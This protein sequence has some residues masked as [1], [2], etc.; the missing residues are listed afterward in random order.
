MKQVGPGGAIRSSNARAAAKREAI[1]GQSAQPPVRVGLVRARVVS[2]DS[3][4]G[5]TVA[6]LNEDGTASA[7]EVTVVFPFP[8]A[9]FA[10]GA[11]VVLQVDRPNAHPWIVGTGAGGAAVDETLATTMLG[12]LSEV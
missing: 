11:D 5:Y 10:A 9:T 1:A 12:L 8:A 3:A 2:G 6:L 7:T 4:A